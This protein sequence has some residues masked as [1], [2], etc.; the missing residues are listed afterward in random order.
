MKKICPQFSNIW[1]KSQKLNTVFTERDF[2]KLGHPQHPTTS[3]VQIDS[4]ESQFLS[5]NIKFSCCYKLFEPQKGLPD[6]SNYHFFQQSQKAKNNQRALCWDNFSHVEKDG[7]LL[8]C[9]F[10]KNERKRR[11]DTIIKGRNRRRSR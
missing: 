4:N 10:K 9:F 1:K 8:F 2:S 6:I 11:E 7:F 5:T 3:G